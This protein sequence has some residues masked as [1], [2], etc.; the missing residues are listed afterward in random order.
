VHG[1]RA[2]KSGH[3]RGTGRRYFAAVLSISAQ[4]CATAEFGSELP[5]NV[6]QPPA[7]T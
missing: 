5:G 4:A 6:A 3:A 1:E 2:A 7:L